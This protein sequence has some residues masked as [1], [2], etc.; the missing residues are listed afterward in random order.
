[1]EGAP[2]KM[3]KGGTTW[4]LLLTL[5]TWLVIVQ[6]NDWLLTHSLGVMET[7]G[8]GSKKQK[9]WAKR[10]GNSGKLWTKDER[11]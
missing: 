11:S 3:E 5:K 4:S 6:S 10:A 2:R 7:A 8:K 9:V 1:M